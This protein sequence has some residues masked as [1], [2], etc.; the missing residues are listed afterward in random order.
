M[1]LAEPVAQCVLS[2]EYAYERSEGCLWGWSLEGKEGKVGIP[3][4]GIYNTKQHWREEVTLWSETND[5]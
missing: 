1:V 2:W 5:A 4:I 3:T